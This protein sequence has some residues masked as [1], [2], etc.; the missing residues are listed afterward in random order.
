MAQRQSG[1][2]DALQN[3]RKGKVIPYPSELIWLFLVMPKEP[4]GVLKVIATDSVE[5]RADLILQSCLKSAKMLQ[6]LEI[7]IDKIHKR[8]IALEK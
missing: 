3:E 2:F 1:Q 5:Q 8:G 4:M 7:Q 6:D